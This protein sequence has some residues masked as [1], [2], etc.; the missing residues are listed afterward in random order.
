MS[1]LDILYFHTRLETP[2]GANRFVVETASHLTE[3]GVSVTLATGTLNHERFPLPE[4]VALLE[5]GGSP[6]GT[7]SHWISL[8][9][10]GHRLR[11]ALAGQSFDAVMFHSI[12]LPYWTPFLRQLFPDAQFYWFAHDPNSYLNTP[13]KLA[14]VPMPLRMLVR[15]GLPLVRLGDRRLI[16]RLDG[17]ISNSKYTASVIK[18]VYGQD[19][20]VV[21]PGVDT[22]AFSPDNASTD[23]EEPYLFTVG[24]LNKFNNFDLLLQA[25]AHADETGADV[26]QLVIGGE[27]PAGPSL[28]RMASRLG[29]EDRVRFTG[30]LS[31][32]E[33]QRHYA[34][35]TAVAYLPNHE[36]FGL[37]PVEAMASGTPVVTLDSGGPKETVIDGTT[38]RLAEATPTAIGD[39]LA[40]VTVPETADRM[41]Q[42][43]REH[44]VERFT[45]ERTTDVLLSVIESVQ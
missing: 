17:I 20:S 7:L 44:V 45:W 33:L 30:Y 27:G 13:G 1:D 22:T 26:P 41:G 36:P 16:A 39:A 42:A 29:I 3:A 43:A 10:L 11:D 5:Y 23:F 38:G 35:A 9:V 14:D 8:P 32:A 37:V 15:A 28:H 31:E 18:R 19:S 21:Y 25:F 24:Q 2:G 40:D 6:P 12:P 34:A 4:D